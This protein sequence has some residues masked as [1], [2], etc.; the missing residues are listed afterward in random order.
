MGWG[1]N[2]CSYLVVGQKL[3]LS[4]GFHPMPAAIP[5]AICGPQVEGTARPSN[6]SALAELNPCP[7]NVCCNVWGQ[8]GLTDDFCIESPAESGAP[9]AVVP[10][11]NG[12]IS[13]CNM[14][15]MNNDSP[16]S[17][18]RVIGY[19]EAWNKYRPCLHQKA[20]QLD[21]EYYTH[22]HFAF[23]NITEDFKV[24]VSGLAQEFYDFKAL[25]GVKR[26]I[27]FGGWS[28]STEHDTYPIFRQGVTASQRQLFASNVASFVKAHRLDGVD[29]DWEYPGAPDIP[30]I[31]A[32]HPD[33]GTNYLA[34]LQLVRDKLGSSYE[35]GI[36]AP[37][38]YWYLKGFPIADISDVVDYIVY[39]TYDL[40][41]QWD[42]DN[43]WATP[44][45]P[46]GNCLRS[47]VN[48]TETELS[49]AMITHAGVPASKVVFGMALYGRSFQM[50]TPGCYGQDCTFTGPESGATPGRC[51]KTAGYL[52]NFEIREIISR[53]TGINTLY[54]DDEGDILVY[55]DVQWVSYMTRE[56]YASRLAWIRG[57]NFG[58]T[59]DWA[60]D[61]DADYPSDADPG[62]G[63]HGVGP[64]Y[65]SPDIYDDPDPVISCRP[66]CTLILPPWVLASPTT[67]T[68]P[69]VTVTYR[70]TWETTVT[71]S[72]VGVVTTSAGSTT[73]TVLTLPPLTTQTIPVSNVVWSPPLGVPT[74]SSSSTDDPWGVIWLTSSI[75]PPPVT[76]T[77]THTRY[78]GGSVVWTFSPGAYPTPTPDPSAPGSP[79]TTGPPPPPPPPPPGHSS[80]VK[81]RSASNPSPTCRP[82]QICGLP[83]II[84][85]SSLKPPCVDV[86]G[87][88]GT[89]CPRG[90]GGGGGSGGCV[91]A[92]CSDPGPGPGPGPGPDPGPTGPE[93]SSCRRKQTASHCKVDC[94]V[95]QYPASSTTRCRDPDCTRTFTACSATD[96]T[97]TTT[98]TYSC[99]A[100]TGYNRGNLD[101][102]APLLGDG[103]EG[104]WV[105]ERGNFNIPPE[106]ITVTDYVTS[107]V[108]RTTTSTRHVTVVEEANQVSCAFWDAYFI[109][110]HFNL[111]GIVDNNGWTN[112]VEGELRGCGALTDWKY[113]AKSGSVLANIWFNLPFFIKEGCVERAI[114]SAGGPKISCKGGGLLWKRSIDAPE[115][116]LT[117]QQP[118]VQP[119]PLIERQ[120]LPSSVVSSQTSTPLYVPTPSPRFMT[121]LPNYSYPEELM[122]TATPVYEPMTWGTEDII[123]MTWTLTSTSTSVSPTT[124]T[125]TIPG[126]TYDPATET[127]FTA[128]S[129]SA[130][131]SSS[132]VPPSGPTT[133]PGNTEYEFHGCYIELSSGR[134]LANVFADDA[135]TVA[136]CLAL[137]T[138]FTYVGLQYGRE[139]FWGNTLDPGSLEDSLS[140]CNMPCGGDA[141]TICGAGSRLTLYIRKDDAPSPYV[142]SVGGYDLV[143]C[144]AA[145]P[146]GRA[147]SLSYADD[148][149]TP[150]MCAGVAATAS[151]TYF[152]LEYGRECWYGN[153]IDSG[154]VMQ[155]SLDSCDMA[156]A[157]DATKKC[158]AG[159][160]L[161]MYEVA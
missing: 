78:P 104:G 48:K 3:C 119:L 131:S 89:F 28:F 33:D 91:G 30:G 29:F 124:Y 136:T 16:P 107:F 39:M 83:C 103:G 108:P 117:E 133:S 129:V 113:Q 105:A 6:W 86:C 158:G 66:P 40:H 115:G 58:G 72:G 127:S 20:R 65:V 25:T 74:A 84:G 106:T 152:G 38:S 69:P 93:T 77:Q 15:I 143:G 21:T 55:D 96:S 23:G 151:A 32:G 68:F 11:S 98:T 12:C 8:C 160:R 5:N 141:S 102:P 101:S 87:C 47:H 100:N 19:W 139:C 111:Y 53:G 145:P 31:P 154:A 17:T 132:S 43:Q 71:R 76:V 49:L 60:A 79:T 97:T 90:G 7:L 153:S 99:P 13:N 92:G 54:S 51:T 44:G 125:T 123:T 110:F 42:Y 138:G 4:L 126:Y 112:R 59:S 52:S 157:G 161:L 50:T 56:T 75:I 144:Y 120:A 63:D 134:A 45:C 27:S 135:M 147:L 10:G 85:C 109:M 70:D 18:F 130:S 64:V 121:E 118:E 95:M 67:I 81:V 26:I 148:D 137:G 57:L 140:A 22:I 9:G 46:A 36:A 82:L 114:V 150:S 24:D 1:W 35:I 34:F 155:S 73:S 146:T 61:L 116:D 80:T 142:D 128:S 14:E 88:I 122:A 156:C 159:N 2:D 94:T 149:M 41:G 37:A 62:Q